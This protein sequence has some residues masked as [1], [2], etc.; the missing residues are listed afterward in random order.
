VDIVLQ[1]SEAIAEAHAHGIV[2]RANLFVTK[3]MDGR[4]LVKVLDFGI[5]KVTDEAQ[6]SSTLTASGSLMAPPAAYARFVV[7]TAPFSSTHAGASSGR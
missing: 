3:R 2:H 6:G 4:S 5:S 1:A 7:P